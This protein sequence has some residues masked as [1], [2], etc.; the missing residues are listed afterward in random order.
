MEEEEGYG[1]DRYKENSGDAG[2]GAGM[3]VDL[4]LD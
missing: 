4:G 3:E 2:E 1:N